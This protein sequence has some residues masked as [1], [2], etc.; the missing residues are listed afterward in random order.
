MFIELASCVANMHRRI[1]CK[2]PLF[3]RCHT[4]C[5]W[6]SYS[7]LSSTRL[8]D[9]CCELYHR[10]L[11]LC[12]V[13]WNDTA[14]KYHTVWCTLRTMS[15][16][17]WVVHHE[18]QSTHI[19]RRLVMLCFT[20]VTRIFCTIFFVLIV[21]HKSFVGWMVALTLSLY[22]CVCLCRVSNWLLCCY[23]LLVGGTGKTIRSPANQIRSAEYSSYIT[24]ETWNSCQ[25]N[26]DG[27]HRI[28]GFINVLN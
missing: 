23:L 14:V 4:A 16:E 6:I 28:Q 5:H 19:H 26:D 11:E 24:D 22:T 17:L 10:N 13:N 15:L 25:P 1:L 20:I 2:P 21:F 9:T 18:L 27:V 3:Y 12:A 8:C 7:T